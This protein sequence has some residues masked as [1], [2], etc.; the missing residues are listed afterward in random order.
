[1]NNVGNIYILQMSSNNMNMI[2][3]LTSSDKFS[4][5]PNAIFSNLGGKL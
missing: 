2:N 3:N 5:T 4:G 1:M